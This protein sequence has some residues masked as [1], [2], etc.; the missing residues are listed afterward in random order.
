MKK[1]KLNVVAILFVYCCLL[2]TT[3]CSIVR[4]VNK[5]SEQHKI[6]TQIKAEAAAIL[7]TPNL[8]NTK[9]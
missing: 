4:F 9:Y 7:I 8:T 3:G 1:F 5:R 6:R 2:I